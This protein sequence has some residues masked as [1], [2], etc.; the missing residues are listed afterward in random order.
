MKVILIISDSFRS[1]HIGCY[2][3]RW[4]H[5][6]NLDRLAARSHV[7]EDMFISCFPTG[8]FRQDVLL[9]KPRNEGLPFNMWDR[10]EEKDL[11][12]P[13]ILGRKRIPSQLITDTANC[14]ARGRNYFQGFTAWHVNRGQE[15]DGWWMDDTIE[16]KSPCPLNMMRYTKERWF[17][18]LLNRAHR[19]VETDWFAPG[20]F[21][22][23]MEWLERN[24]RR[25][26]FFLWIDTFDPHE[27]WDPPQHYTDLYDP[28][29]KG[30]VLEA[31][32]YG[33]RKK[34]G[35]TDRQLK[36]IRA[37][38]AG[39]CTM[40]DTWVGNLLA[41]V[42]RLGI[43]DDTA[44]IFTS[45]HGI[46][47]DG[48]GD[49]G[50]ICKPHSVGPD[51]VRWFRGMGH[52]VED[53]EFFPMRPNL[54][55]TPLI[56]RL[57]GQRSGK[58]LKGFTQARDIM[59]TILALFGVAAPENVLGKSFLPMMER[60]RLSPRDHVMFGYTSGQAQICN[61][62]WLY[63]SWRGQ[64][65]CMLFDRRKDANITTD[66]AR[67]HP[68]VVKRLH[69]QLLKDMRHAGADEEFLAAFRID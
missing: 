20:T 66:V 10:L 62:Q 13:A 33:L 16:L 57:P 63:A 55:N 5:T 37:R 19:K 1:D 3:N 42:E 12:L 41:T 47:L 26:D 48:P 24:H 45:D 61:R 17:Q 7:F 28:G 34:I 46:Y 65:P 11:T 25:K 50:L 36:H 21:K 67:K 22:L 14:V 64:R 53:T 51:G 35:I 9:G 23:A 6:P 56:V 39:E 52:K 18:V 59:P 60:N 69:S 58:R 32:P 68:N 2:G 15:G 31:P 43:D 29:Y 44:V 40:V 54:A 38:Y 8:P 49:G 30:V 27:P 4:I